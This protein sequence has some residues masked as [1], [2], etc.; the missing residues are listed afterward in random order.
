MLWRAGCDVTVHERIGEELAEP[1]L[2]HSAL[3][4]APYGLGGSH[5]GMLGVL[6]PQRMD[7]AHIIPLV[8]Y[9]S[10]LLSGKLEA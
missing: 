7:Y 1:G 10:G 8:D 6:G 4:G 5:L 9:C 3:V 2:L